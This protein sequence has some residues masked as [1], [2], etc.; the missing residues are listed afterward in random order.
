MPKKLRNRAADNWRA[1][2]AIADACGGGWGRRARDAAVTLARGYFEEDPGV[3][4]LRDI[5]QVF[6]LKP[7]TDR[8]VSAALVAALLDLEGAPWAEWRGLRD[9]QQPRKL[10]QGELAKLLAPF[11][12]WPRS[13]WLGQ[14][15]V[16]SKSRKGYVKADFGPAWAAY[17]GAGGTSGT[18][19]TPAQ[20]RKIRHLRSG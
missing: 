11:R 2:F 12:I 17:C 8:I 4:L 13:I 10:S 16:A 5:R 20:S 3:T 19:G 1:L 15:T 14:R 7:E 18:G 9:D 6:E